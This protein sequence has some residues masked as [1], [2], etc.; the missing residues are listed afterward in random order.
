MSDLES[1]DPG[2]PSGGGTP[3]FNGEEI[4]QRQIGALFGS[5]PIEPLSQLETMG[6]LLDRLGYQLP[7]LAPHEQRS[8]DRIGR[9]AVDL[10]LVPTQIVSS[11]TMGRRELSQRARLHL[12]KQK[13]HENMAVDV[14]RMPEEGYVYTQ[15]LEDPDGVAYWD[16]EQNPTVEDESGVKAYRLVYK[17]PDQLRGIRLVEHRAEYIAAL[18]GARLA[19]ECE[20]GCWTFPSMDVRVESPRNNN[21]AVV[22]YRSTQA[23]GSPEALFMTQ[24]LHQANGTAEAR[25]IDYGNEAAFEIDPENDELIRPAFISTVRLREQDHRLGLFARRAGSIRPYNGVR[26]VVSGL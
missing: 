13:L 15:L 14:M 20:A 5:A 6:L 12:P 21:S 7:K 8:I 9:R 23:I 11:P 17:A 24:V 18:L 16:W 4:F 10:R 2:E 22:N 25:N 19:V 3:N 1:L 26:E